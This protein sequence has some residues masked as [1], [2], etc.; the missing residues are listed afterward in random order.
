[1][2]K[3][4][5]IMTAVLMVFGAVGNAAAYFEKDSGHIIM[6]IY[7]EDG[8]EVGIDLGDGDS[9][10]GA[11]AGTMNL[12]YFEP[13]TTWD[14][15]N[16]GIWGQDFSFS[17][18]VQGTGF[19][20]ATTTDADPGFS[21]NGI[22]GFDASNRSVMGYYRN[23]QTGNV[24]VGEISH[25][26]S[27]DY[28]FN[29]NSN[30]PGSYAFTKPPSGAPGETDLAAIATGDSVT[31]Y[32]HKYALDGELFVYA[33]NTAITLNADGSVTTSAVPVPGAIYLMGTALVAFF[34]VRRR[35]S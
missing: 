35:R 4:L 7:Q 23:L 25:V 13:G 15:L 1:M 2:K 33:G 32:L 5:L 30:A 3:I 22:G 17:E 11:S 34:G 12:G 31:M 18:V 19:Y 8:K 10:V 21:L 29:A 9:L 28:K 27:Y 14:Q 16:M 24:A 26:L 6:S 20:Y